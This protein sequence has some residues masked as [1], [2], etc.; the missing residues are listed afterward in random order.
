MN[1][2]LN[3]PVEPIAIF[4]MVVIVLAGFA[5]WVF[6]TYVDR[7]HRNER[8]PRNYNRYEEGRYGDGH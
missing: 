5:T 1:I 3:L 7:D 4:I 2:L 8:K 6:L